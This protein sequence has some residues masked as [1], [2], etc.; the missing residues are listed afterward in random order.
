[1]TISN[2]WGHKAYFSLL[3]SI[4]GMIKMQ[5]NIISIILW[6]KDGMNG[7]NILPLIKSLIQCRWY[8]VEQ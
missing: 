6:Q 2:G 1:M 5:N 4:L 3:M 7:E 8:A